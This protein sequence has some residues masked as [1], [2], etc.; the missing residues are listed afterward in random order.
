MADILFDEINDH[1]VMT[2]PD[3]EL[4]GSYQT[5]AYRTTND[6]PICVYI[7]DSWDIEQARRRHEATCIKYQPKEPHAC[8]RCGRKDYLPTWSRVFQEWLCPSC[9]DLELEACR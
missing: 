3:R 1:L 6:I 4:D 7:R 8:A 9:L 2:Y 5:R